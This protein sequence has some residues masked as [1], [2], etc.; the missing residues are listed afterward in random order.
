[1]Q[2]R[3]WIFKLGD[4]DDHPAIPH[5]QAQEVG[6]RLNAWTGEIYPAGNEREKMLGKLTAKELQ[7]LHK[8]TGFLKFAMK[9]IEW[10]RAEF[11]YISFFVP[12]WFELKY[13]KAC[14]GKMEKENNINEYIFIAKA[15]IQ[16][17]I[18]NK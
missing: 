14:R 18:S 13:M 7:R 16:N 9:Q 5:A 8:D 11:P 10:Y 3:I 6:Y 15:N 17:E 2:N 1:M 12:D 4:A